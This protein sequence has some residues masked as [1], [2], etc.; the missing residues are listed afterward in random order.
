MGAAVW[1]AGCHKQQ[2][3]EKVTIKRATLDNGLRVVAVRNPLAHVAT[4]YL[5]YIAGGDDTP[6][7]FP[8]M[9]H[10]QE[11]IAPLRCLHAEGG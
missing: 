11:H 8:G 6:P 4:V 1:L 2:P 7:G 5:N 10:A 9:A 3:I